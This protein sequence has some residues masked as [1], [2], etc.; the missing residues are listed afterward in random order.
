[1]PQ[2]MDSKTTDRKWLGRYDCPRRDLREFLERAEN[3]GEVTQVKVANWNF[4][5][6]ALAEIEARF[7]PRNLTF[8]GLIAT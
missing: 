3:V 8:L 2:T 4:G 1:M 7:S 6:G 5:L